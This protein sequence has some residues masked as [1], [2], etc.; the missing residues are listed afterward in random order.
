M[1][2]EPRVRRYLIYGLLD[3]RDRTLRYV[4]KTHLRRGI[5]LERHMQKA[6]EGA[7]APV[8]EWIRE[9]NAQ[10]LRPHIFVLR[11]MSWDQ[12]WRKGEREMIEL[13]LSWSPDELPVTIPPQTPKSSVTQIRGVLLLNVQAGG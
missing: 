4:G 1:I 10:G 8:G 3:P 6:L 12:D 9:L 2:S 13:W 7:R 5:R 11:R